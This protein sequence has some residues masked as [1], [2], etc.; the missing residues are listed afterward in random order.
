MH[1]LRIAAKR[2]NCETVTTAA[3]RVADAIEQFSPNAIILFGSAA[4]DEA[5]DQSDIDILVICDSDDDL[6][7]A[8][9]G[10]RKVLPKTV[11]PIDLIWMTVGE[12]ERKKD[13]GGIAFIA[14]REGKVLF[15]KCERGVDD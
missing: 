13:L 4:R 6:T 12:F 8:R 1:P 7:R 5:T 2:L 11:L 9:K 15:R 3:E 10:V 14:S